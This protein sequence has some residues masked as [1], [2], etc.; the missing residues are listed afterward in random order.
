MTAIASAQID[1][2]KYLRLLARALPRTIA[3]EEENKRML[4]IVNNLIW[5]SSFVFRPR[6]S[7]DSA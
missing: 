2:K 3:T 1:P 6:Y 5:P 7:S 4:A